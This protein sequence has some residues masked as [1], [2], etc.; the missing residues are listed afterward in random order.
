MINKSKSKILR[1]KTKNKERKGVLIKLPK[2]N[3]DLRTDLPTIG[4][5]TVKN[6]IKAGLRGIEIEHRIT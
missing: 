3:Q 4:F 6:C 5:K 2:P 1:H